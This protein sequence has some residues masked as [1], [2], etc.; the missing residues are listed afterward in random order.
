MTF[1]IKQKAKSYLYANF[2]LIRFN[3]KYENVISKIKNNVIKLKKMGMEAHL[4]FPDIW[5]MSLRLF[6]AS[7]LDW[8]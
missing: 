1:P 6:H 3:Q 7:C 8:Y 4:T 2:C 5:R